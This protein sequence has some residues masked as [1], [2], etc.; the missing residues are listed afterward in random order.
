MTRTLVSENRGPHLQDGE[1]GDLWERLEDA[2][3]VRI[4]L[5]GLLMNLPQHGI[6]V[7]SFR[8]STSL[9]TFFS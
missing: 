6:T 7:F 5:Q 2:E 9:S 4:I 8:E 1:L 3:H